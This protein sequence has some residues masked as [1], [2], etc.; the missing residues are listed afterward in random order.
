MSQPDKIIYFVR[1]GQTQ[2][3]AT[4]VKQGDKGGLSELGRSQALATA[5]RFPRG[6]GHPQIIIA[7]PYERTQETAK[8]I[9]EEL[10]G[11]SIKTSDL[12]KERRNPSTIIGHSR[13]EE[14]IH[15]IID[16]MDNTFHSDD[17]RIADEENFSD[18]KARAK[19]L[20]KYIKHRSQKRIIMV[21]H[22][23]F[24]KMVAAYITYGDTLSASQYNTLSYF[25]PID[26]AS[27]CVVAYT[28]HWFS[29]DKWEMLVW[30]DLA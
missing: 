3:N 18:L 25:N 9:S 11:I 17:F 2:N 15:E 12:L 30:N 26:N 20:L 27:M 5:Q 28:H 8:I 22:G 19:K 6:K 29:R 21:S 13:H 7:S 1:H 10:G 24:L 16:K 14:G 4:G 23:F